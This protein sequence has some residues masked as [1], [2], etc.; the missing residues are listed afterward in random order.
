MNRRELQQDG[1]TMVVVALV[2]LESVQ[3]GLG[4]SE[5]RVKKVIHRYRA[6]NTKWKLQKR[7]CR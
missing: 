6:E 4:V 2:K 1:V 5:V 7:Q 3:K